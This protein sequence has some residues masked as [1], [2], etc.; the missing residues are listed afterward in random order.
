MVPLD[1]VND[2]HYNSEKA[3][4]ITMLRIILLPFIS[5][6]HRIKIF[7]CYDFTILTFHVLWKVFHETHVFLIL[8]IY[9]KGSNSLGWKVGRRHVKQMGEFTIHDPLVWFLVTWFPLLMD[10]TNICWCIW[11]PNSTLSKEPGS[12]LQLQRNV[13]ENWESVLYC[14]KQLRSDVGK[15]SFNIASFQSSKALGLL[16]LEKRSSEVT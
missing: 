15:I 9:W 6:R 11:K 13:L 2:V 4:K 10:N 1:T 8:K 7:L 16:S 5:A 3:S 14:K 12:S